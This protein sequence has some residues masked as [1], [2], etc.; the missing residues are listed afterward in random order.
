MDLI[1]LFHRFQNTVEAPFTA[2]IAVSVL[3]SICTNFAHAET[4]AFAC[5]FG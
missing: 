4:T 2:V 1:G 3:E 5:S